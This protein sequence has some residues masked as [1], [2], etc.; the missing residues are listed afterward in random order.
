MSDLLD[1]VRAL[2]PVPD[3]E[4]PAIQDVWSKLERGRTQ[5]EGAWTAPAAV[6]RPVR[7]RR[8]SPGHRFPGP[9][10]L[11]VSA[12]VTVLAAIAAA[13]LAAVAAPGLRATRSPVHAAPAAAVWRLANGTISC[14]LGPGGAG[15]RAATVPVPVRGRSAVAVCRRAYRAAGRS[16]SGVTFTECATS[17]TNVAVYIADGRPGQ[18][19]R[20]GDRPIPPG[21]AAA[22]RRSASAGTARTASE[23]T[24]DLR[25]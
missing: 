9:R 8:R 17:A 13:A 12:T 3:C 1:S 4:A 25:A 14:D 10:R 18:C 19:H 2:N 21:Y 7:R 11:T 15:D 5:T 20:H 23:H 6:A 16:T 24:A 22:V